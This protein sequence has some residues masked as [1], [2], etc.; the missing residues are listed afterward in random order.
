EID[1][2]A[3]QV[4]A[5]SVAPANRHA[6]DL[7]AASAVDGICRGAGEAGG[8]LVQAVVACREDPLPGVLGRSQLGGPA[9]IIELRHE[10]EL[11]H[12]RLTISWPYTRAHTVHVYS[13]AV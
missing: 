4:R 11:G 2:L 12:D 7:I 6:L 9:P 8:I 5:V 1:L 10:L 13:H 3:W